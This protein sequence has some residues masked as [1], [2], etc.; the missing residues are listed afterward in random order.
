MALATQRAQPGARS[1]PA[2]SWSIAARLVPGVHDRRAAVSEITDV[3]GCDH[4]VLR[5]GDGCNQPVEAVQRAP[6]PLACGDQLSIE[7]RRGCIEPE[8]SWSEPARG[9]GVKLGFEV[10]PTPA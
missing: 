9:E 3:A 2:S 5:S 4:S 7:R 1:G 6:S 8:H 10:E